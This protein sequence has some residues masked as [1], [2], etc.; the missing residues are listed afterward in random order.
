MESWRWQRLSSRG[1]TGR[2]PGP[3]WAT[4]TE[5]G[6]A[7]EYAGCLDVQSPGKHEVSPRGLAARMMVHTFLK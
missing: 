4:S 7:R 1:H 6:G 5:L 2:H 3:Y